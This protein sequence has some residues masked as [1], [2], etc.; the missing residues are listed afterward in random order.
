MKENTLFWGVRPRWS[1]GFWEKPSP[2]HQIKQLNTSPKSQQLLGWV[3]GDLRRWLNL[4]LSWEHWVFI[5]FQHRV[6]QKSAPAYG[7]R[8][9]A[10][11][12]SLLEPQRPFL[13]S[14]FQ[15]SLMPKKT[16]CFELG[17]F[18]AGYKFQER[19][20]CGDSM[21]RAFWQCFSVCSFSSVDADRA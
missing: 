13:G 4:N 2:T 11:I 19:R 18:H 21:E 6:L 14:C 3:D 15:R 9:C 1:L 8:H 5:H 7:I 16:L 12:V 17:L 10:W 20:W